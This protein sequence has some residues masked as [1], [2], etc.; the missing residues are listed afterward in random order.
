VPILALSGDVALTSIV[1]ARGSL[2]LASYQLG[3][4]PVLQDLAGFAASTVAPWALLVLFVWV[5]MHPPVPDRSARPGADPDSDR[6]M[7]TGS[8]R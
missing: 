3:P 6:L 2:M 4:G 1:A 5:V 7:R 8:N